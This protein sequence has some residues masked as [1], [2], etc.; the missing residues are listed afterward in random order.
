MDGGG[1]GGCLCGIIHVIL[2]CSVISESTLEF[3]I[4]TFNANVTIDYETID[5][6]LLGKRKNVNLGLNDSKL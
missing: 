1:L 6:T 4:H 2:I 5:Y 3:W